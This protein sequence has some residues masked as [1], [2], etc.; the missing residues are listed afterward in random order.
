[1]NDTDRVRRIVERLPLLTSYQ[2]DSIDRIITQLQGPKD[3]KRNVQS[4]LVTDAVLQDFGDAL[5]VHHTYSAEALSKDRFE[6]ALEQ[7]L[8]GRRIRAKRAPKGN[9][10]HDIT[11]AGIACSLKTQADKNI[12]S[13]VIHISKYMELGKGDW[14]DK[15]DDLRGLLARFQAHLARY[16]RIFTLRRLRHA[17]DELYEL[18]EIPKGLLAKAGVGALSIAAN[19]RQNPKPGYCIVSDRQGSVEFELYFDGGTERK[20]QVRRLRKDLC[21]VHATWQFPRREADAEP[22]ADEER[23]L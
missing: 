14:T 6:Y 9:P 23:D 12:K 1:V 5:R 18:V 11:I 2:L 15:V 19:S 13:D 8:Q 10:G 16:E 4:D 17:T 7:V 20:L 22:V 3:F 21:T